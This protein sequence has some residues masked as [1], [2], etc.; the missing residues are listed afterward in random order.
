MVDADKL[1]RAVEA[2]V[3]EGGE[4]ELLARETRGI[5]GSSGASR[6]RI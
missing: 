2:V 6:R 5:L 1:V 4:A 3:R